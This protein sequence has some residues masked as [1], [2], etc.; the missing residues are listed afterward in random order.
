MTREGVKEEK[1]RVRKEVGLRSKERLK[2]LFEAKF[3]TDVDNPALESKVDRKMVEDMKY[4]D[5]MMVEGTSANQDPDDC[6][7]FTTFVGISAAMVGVLCVG[8][9]WM[10]WCREIMTKYS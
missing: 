9:W 4:D 2:L 8:L 6:G 7:E 10:G 3:K 1:E 5:E